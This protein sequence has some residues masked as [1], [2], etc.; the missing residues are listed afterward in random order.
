M[1]LEIDIVLLQVH[2]ND[3]E[4]DSRYREELELAIDSS[5]RLSRR[6]G[7]GIENLLRIAGPFEWRMSHT[8]LYRFLHVR[9][10]FEAPTR[11]ELNVNTETKNGLVE[12]FDKYGVSG[13]EAEPRPEARWAVRF[14]SVPERILPPEAIRELWHLL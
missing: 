13:I 3:F 10:F 11:Y 1:G 7:R 8:N 2:D 5:G 4:D 12:T 9:R 6:A 14:P